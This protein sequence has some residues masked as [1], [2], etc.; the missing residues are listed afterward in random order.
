MVEGFDWGP[1]VTKAI[2]TLD[3]EVN[4]VTKDM[5]TTSE[6]KT[7]IGEQSIID[8]TAEQIKPFISSSFTFYY[9]SSFIIY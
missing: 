1:G 2:I 4:K 3:S 7:V 5:F 9:L 6:A 8:T